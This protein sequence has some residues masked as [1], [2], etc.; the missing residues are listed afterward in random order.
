MGRVKDRPAAQAT[1]PSLADKLSANRRGRLTED[2]YNQVVAHLGRM[3]RMVWVGIAL[4]I[5]SPVIALGLLWLGSA[6]AVSEFL[7]LLAL[8]LGLGTGVRIVMEV[9][10][11]NRIRPILEERKVESRQVEIVEKWGRG[12]V[13]RATGKPIRYLG[14]SIPIAP[15][16][17][18]IYF[19]QG[20][21]HAISCETLETRQGA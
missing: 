10:R 12:S 14:W 9:Y 7:A 19:V 4:A 13:D 16:R 1:N 11:N 3:R 6:N 5:G 18:R 21:D 20:T 8:F 2:Q 15:G 17:Y